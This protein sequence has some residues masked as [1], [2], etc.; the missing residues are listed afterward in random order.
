M[1]SPINLIKQEFQFLLDEFNFS[2]EHEMYSY[3]TMGNALVIFKSPTTIVKVVV[4]RSQAFLTIGMVS[5]P[6]RE[7]F[8]F[9]DV[10]HFFAPELENVYAFEGKQ[11][12]EHPNVET[13]I[14]HIAFLL[15]QYCKPLLL[16]D[17]SMQDKIKE[18]ETKRVSDMLSQFQKLSNKSK[19]A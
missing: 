8:E 5:W 1:T 6:D 3:E 10:V 14:G 12:S 13:Q 17:F 16:G 15:C 18:I 4:D 7:W 9:I 19:K 2:V 11:L